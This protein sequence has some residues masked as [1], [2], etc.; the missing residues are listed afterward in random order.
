MLPESSYTMAIKRLGAPPAARADE[1]EAHGSV[2]NKHNANKQAT[3]FAAI[4]RLLSD[5]MAD[6]FFVFAFN[7]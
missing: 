5:F 7:I 2:N 4:G 6:R 3:A 1:P